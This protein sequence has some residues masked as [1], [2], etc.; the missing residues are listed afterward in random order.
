MGALSSECKTDQADLQIGCPSHHVTSWMKSS[1]ILIQIAKAFN[2][3]GIAENIRMIWVEYFDIA[4]LMIYLYISH[5]SE[6]SLH[7]FFSVV[8]SNRGNALGKDLF[9]PK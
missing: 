8:L 1:L 3:Y 6:S 2:Q 9:L 5:Q 7:L 4:N